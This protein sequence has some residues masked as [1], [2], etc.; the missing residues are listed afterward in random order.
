MTRD[1]AAQLCIDVRQ[2]LT[3]LQ[4]QHL[5]WIADSDSFGSV[6]YQEL[7]IAG[8]LAEQDAVVLCLPPAWL[9]MPWHKL[10]DGYQY[11]ALEQPLALILRDSPP[12]QPLQQ[13]PIRILLTTS[14]SSGL[15][16]P[17]DQ[18]VSEFA[19]RYDKLTAR[20][21][22]AVVDRAVE[23]QVSKRRLLTALRKACQNG[24][25]PHIWHHSGDIRVDAD[26][27][28]L[29]LGDDELSANSLR[30][31]LAELC[32]DEAS[33]LRLFLL[34]TNA[35]APDLLPVLAELPVPAAVSLQRGEAEGTLLQ[36]LYRRLLATDLAEAVYLARLDRYIE[37]Q[38][39]QDWEG[40]GLVT[41]AR[42]LSFVP[43]DKRQPWLKPRVPGRTS[44]FLFLHANPWNAAPRPLAIDKELK[45]IKRALRECRDQLQIFESGA[46]ERVDL[47]LALLEYQP[48]L[49][50]FSGHAIEDGAI[51]LVAADGEFVLVEPERIADVVAQFVTIRCIVLNAC[52]G[53]RLA[54]LLKDRGMVVVSMDGTILDD[55]SI[56]FA[57]SF[58][59]ALA[60]GMT[61][62]KA[63]DVAKA[64]IGL[65][66]AEDEAARL[67]IS[68]YEAA[69]SIWFFAQEYPNS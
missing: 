63:Y 40:L 12:P 45:V 11:I 15:Q 31:L 69:R 16:P 18:V 51:V 35:S 26:G 41:H 53:T 29:L 33:G 68:D 14:S 3:P 30:T 56:H 50:H 25:P 65:V 17:D 46:L 62:A 36:G 39:R 19:R 48:D 8:T 67:E 2:Y 24:E 66:G 52:Y 44:R 47:S 20:S 9:S 23:R 22:V 32:Q 42:P 61:L 60:H 21:G 58:Y 28:T 38:D 59:Q 6:A 43:G 1:T 37:A 57:R 4:L 13:A 34:H 49:L 7:Q 55:T 54:E 64:E 10:R 5:Q 27:L